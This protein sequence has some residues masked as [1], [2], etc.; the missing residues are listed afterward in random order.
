MQSMRQLTIE[1]LAAWVLFILLFAMAVRVPLD[2][3]VWW[4]LKSGNY[5][6]EEGKILREDIFSYTKNGEAWINHSWGS[7]VIMTLAYRATGG[8]MDEIGFGGTWGLALYT[9]IFATAGMALVYRCCVGNVYTRAFVVIIAG[10]TAAVFWSPRPQMVS[11]FLSTV[12][13]YLLHLYKRQERDYLWLLI[14]FMALWVNLHGGFVLGFI[15]LAG[16][17]AGE[18]AANILS[19]NDPDTLGWQ[20]WR[21]LIWITVA[22]VLALSLNPYG[23]RMIL[24]PLDTA[25]LSTL[26]LFIAEW[27]S[28]NFKEPQTW[29]F[30]LMIFGLITFAGLARRRMEWSDMTLVLGTLLLALWAGRNIALFAVVAAPA[31]SRLVD[32]FLTEQG[33]QIHPMRKVQGFRLIL[34]WVLLILILLGALGKI[35]VTLNQESVEELQQ[36]YFPLEA[37]A[38]LEQNPPEGNII[39]SYNWGGLLMF[40]V[41]SIPVFVDG[42]T[43][44]YGDAFLGDYFK[45][46]F[47]SSQWR[48]VLNEWDIQVALLSDESALTSLLREEW[49]VV[50]EDDQAAVLI[51]KEPE[52]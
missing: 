17:I 33:W 22:S 34:N 7:Q 16:F 8:H 5:L 51:A 14:P 21:K 6:L 43:D 26:N 12:V 50:Y 47:G 24:Y 49:E 1:R 4:H 2:T 3:D 41:P 20:R 19:P 36:D 18:A 42:R 9:A 31:L 25:G 32:A 28:P 39:N 10:A 35:V 11:F 52:E 30:V 27:L 13:L 15:I 29:A 40:E 45:A 38:Y 44:L 48:D 46:Q 37:L 23:P